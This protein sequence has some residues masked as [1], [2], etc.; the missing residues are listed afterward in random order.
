MPCLYRSRAPELVDPVV[1]AECQFNMTLLQDEVTAYALLA[2]EAA[3]ESLLSLGG[4][5]VVP[6]TSS[7]IYTTR[8]QAI[9]RERLSRING[10]ETP[11]TVVT[12]LCAILRL[13]A[14]ESMTASPHVHLH[15]NAIRRLLVRYSELVGVNFDRKVIMDLLALVYVDVS[16][17]LLRSTGPIL[18]PNDWIPYLNQGSK[19]TSQ[20]FQYSETSSEVLNIGIVHTD[21]K[22]ETLRSIIRNQRGALVRYHQSLERKSDPQ[23][24]GL[25]SAGLGKEILQIVQ[26]LNIISKPVT[27]FQTELSSERL[28]NQKARTYL[29]LS[30]LL[31]SQLALPTSVVTNMLVDVAYPTLHRLRKALI[32]SKLDQSHG[33]EAS[34]DARLWALSVGVFT[35]L[36]RQ[37]VSDLSLV[38]GHWFFDTFREEVKLM[39]VRS[40]QHAASIFKQFLYSD[41]IEPH[42]SQWWH[43]VVSPIESPILK[44]EMSGNDIPAGVKTDY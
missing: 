18:E 36:H 29:A 30:I 19:D 3:L 35:E 23:A 37:K 20:K 14:A 26:L 2:R 15:V 44:L 9:L 11:S 25:L 38:C 22:D 5:D 43:Q 4:R 21:V 41:R 17:A 28:Q 16:Q 31:W 13:A 42:M 34:A 27:D 8:C 39:G 12:I 33:S 10:T 1:H 24:A 7:L 40:W 6:S 32:Q